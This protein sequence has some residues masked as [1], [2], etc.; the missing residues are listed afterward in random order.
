MD[1]AKLNDWIQ[2][3]GIFAVVASLI[4]V[5]LQMKQSQEIAVANLY[6][7]RANVE[8]MWWTEVLDIDE[9]RRGWGGE[10]QKWLVSTNNPNGTNGWAKDKSTEEIGFRYIQSMS[11][12]AQIDS[13][14]FQYQAGFLDEDSWLAYR[15]RMKPALNKPFIQDYFAMTASGWR[16]AFIDEIDAA[17]KE[18]ESQAL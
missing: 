16:K 18:L 14:L 15:N 12:Y 11:L 1:S 8:V 9:S 5:G 7:E 4:F 3:I 10:M 17:R 2:V 13:Q 6:Q